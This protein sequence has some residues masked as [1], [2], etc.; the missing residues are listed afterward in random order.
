MDFYIRRT[1]DGECTV[2]C[3]HLNHCSVWQQEAWYSLTSSVTDLSVRNLVAPLSKESWVSPHGPVV[4][5]RTRRS[6]RMDL[7]TAKLKGISI[8]DCYWWTASVHIPALSN[9]LEVDMGVWRV[10][11]GDEDKDISDSS[12]QGC[13]G[14]EMIT[15]SSDCLGISWNGSK[16]LVQ[17]LG[18]WNAVFCRRTLCLSLV[19]Q[20]T[21]KRIRICAVDMLFSKLPSNSFLWESLMNAGRGNGKLTGRQLD[22]A[23]GRGKP[24]PVRCKW[25]QKVNSRQPR[26]I[27]KSQKKSQ[28]E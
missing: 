20:A 11:E 24:D 3:H 17:R 15:S 22:D 27:Q 7:G 9:G 13:F 8:N 4:C 25:S 18:I 1:D 23:A 14:A 28:A 6:V 12:S 2:W 16:G 10:G 21:Y 26:D 5:R 19:W